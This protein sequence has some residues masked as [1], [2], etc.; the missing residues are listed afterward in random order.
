VGG[1]AHKPWR[2]E[3]AEP[4]LPQGARAFTAQ[5]FAFAHPTEDNAFKLPLAERTLA[6]VL[7][8]ART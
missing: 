4:A 5:A 2:L 7:Q 3:T 8:E 1:V 6:S